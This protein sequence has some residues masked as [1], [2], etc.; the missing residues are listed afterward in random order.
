MG[1]AWDTWF[2]WFE[3][4]ET[5]LIVTGYVTGLFRYSKHE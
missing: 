3:D 2:D 1:T 5:G 4:A